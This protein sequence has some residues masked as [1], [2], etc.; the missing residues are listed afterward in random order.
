MW[1]CAYVVLCSNAMIKVYGFKI[2]RHLSC[3]VCI[4]LTYSLEDG[5]R[6]PV[7]FQ[8]AFLFIVHA[9]NQLRRVM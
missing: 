5:E 8:F 7:W 4:I 6:G 2:F 1:K 9:Y 3:S